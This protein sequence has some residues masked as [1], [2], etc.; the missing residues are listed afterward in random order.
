MYASTFY[1]IGVLILGKNRV[2][3]SA[4]RKEFGGQWGTGPTIR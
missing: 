1:I 4:H 3:H 2:G